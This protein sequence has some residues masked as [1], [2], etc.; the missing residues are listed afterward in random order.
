MKKQNTITMWILIGIIALIVIFILA[1]GRTSLAPKPTPNG[2]GNTQ[3][4]SEKDDYDVSEDTEDTEEIESTETTESEEESNQP[5]KPAGVTAS[6]DTALFIGDSRTVGIQTY[7]KELTATA[8]FFAAVSTTITGVVN[9]ND[10]IDVEGVGN[11]TISELLSQKKYDKIYIM[12]GINEASDYPSN[13]ARNTQK[14]LDLIQEKQPGSVIFI[15]ANLYVSETYQSSR[16]A[17][18][19]ANMQAINNAQAALANNQDIFYLDPNF[20]FVDENGNLSMDYSG[21]GCHLQNKSCD[22]L[23]EWIISETKRI[24]GL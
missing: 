13:I 7:T 6:M 23:V 14:L 18:S 16:P 12:L 8:D 20:M 2:G 22:K 15:V 4:E 3:Q 17:F 19:T 24:L 10:K 9:Y 11:V 21:D 1:T 5:S